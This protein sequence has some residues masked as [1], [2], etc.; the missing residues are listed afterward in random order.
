MQAEELRFSCKLDLI[1]LKEAVKILELL[2]PEE[3]PRN[4][5]GI[6]SESWSL[7]KEN[8]PKTLSFLHPQVKQ[9]LLDCLQKHNLRF[10]V[11]G[12]DVGSK[13]WYAKYLESIFPRDYVPRRNLAGQSVAGAPAP[14]PA[15]GSPIPSPGPA[16]STS[17]VPDSDPPSPSPKTP[18][19][20]P[21]TSDSNLG[22]PPAENSSSGPDS[23]SN[24]SN[25]KSNKHRS[26]V[27]AVAVT[28]SI[29]FVIVALLFLCCS[30]FCRTGSKVG[31]NDERPL[32]S[33]SLSDFSIGMHSLASCYCNLLLFV[34]VSVIISNFLSFRIFT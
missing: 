6:N 19:F 33:L 31:R 34:T 28:A 25:K 26:V 16:P 11:S 8:I 1:H 5:H 21:I 2:F 10:P 27:I 13:I 29:T 24:V 3:I 23:G 4:F 20:P 9:A 32:L 7:A 12:G 18:F 15:V 30:G 17:Q 22:G 14:A